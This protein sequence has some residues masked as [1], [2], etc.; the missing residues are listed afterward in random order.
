MHGLKFDLKTGEP[1][2]MGRLD[3]L[4]TY[5]VRVEDGHVLIGEDES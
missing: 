5:D 3:N 4:K 1:F 2:T